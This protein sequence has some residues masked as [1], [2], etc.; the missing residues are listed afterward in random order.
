MAPIGL[1][2]GQGAHRALAAEAGLHSAD[3]LLAAAR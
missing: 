3:N 1:A 2:E